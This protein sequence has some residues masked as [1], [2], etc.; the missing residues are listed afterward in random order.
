MH[1]PVQA[2]QEKSAVAWLS[3]CSQYCEFEVH[4]WAGL[5]QSPPG[6]IELEVILSR[7]L[8]A[9]LVSFV[10]CWQEATGTSLQGCFKWPQD[11]ASAFAKQ[12]SK[13]N[14][15]FRIPPHK[16]PSSWHTSPFSG[17]D[18]R[19]QGQSG[20]LLPTPSCM[21]FPVNGL[22]CLLPAQLIPVTITLGV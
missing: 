2:L 17:W 3:G 13:N 12:E 5:P 18:F 14:T 8:I 1:Y 22:F 11:V 15:S 21:V 10:G 19:T 4:V 7:C 20:T 16:T 6:L 9:C